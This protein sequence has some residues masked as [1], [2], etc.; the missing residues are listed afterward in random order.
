[1]PYKQVCFDTYSHAEQG[2]RHPQLLEE[3]LSWLTRLPDLTS[4]SSLDSA[5]AEAREIQDERLG[6]AGGGEEEK[7]H[8][9]LG[10]GGALLDDRLEGVC[11]CD[12]RSGGW[13]GALY[14][15]VYVC[16]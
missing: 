7:G 9:D 11:V 8:G 2:E 3:L 10:G 13:V 1:M 16:G 4:H 5:P 15:N 14:V 6:E 12:G